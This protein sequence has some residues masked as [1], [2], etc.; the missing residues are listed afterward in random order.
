M[1]LPTVEND[2]SDRRNDLVIRHLDLVDAATRHV[3]RR[4]GAASL[5]R[6]DLISEGRVALI[7]AA[8]RYDRHK[9]SFR[10]YAFERVK[11]AIIDA[12]RRD[13]YLSR[14]ARQ[15]GDSVELVSLEKLISERGLTISDT[16]VDSGPSVEELVE[17]RERLAV[18]LTRQ[19]P[20]GPPLD[21]LTPSELEV[22]RGAALGETAEETA[23]RLSKSVDTVK[24]Q[25]RTALRRLGAKSIAQAVFIARERI[26]A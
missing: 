22:L 13:H 7:T 10:S 20:D 5:D 17:Q 6:D 15:R 2:V 26:A 8:T 3:S 12:I 23:D 14:H 25:R 16:L 19:E 24:T 4:M 1:R 18:A 11:G 9:G 21:G